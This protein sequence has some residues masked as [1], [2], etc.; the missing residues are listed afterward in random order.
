[1]RVDR[2]VFGKESEC[3]VGITIV[4]LAMRN[5]TGAFA[6]QQKSSPENTRRKTL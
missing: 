2:R 1:M 3:V 6:V 4:D 5:R